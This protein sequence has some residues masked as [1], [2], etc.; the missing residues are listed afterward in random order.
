MA[1]FYTNSGSFNDLK[2]SGSTIMSASSGAVLQLKSSGSTIFSVSGSGG[3]IFN[4]S[5]IGSSTALFTVS[6][7][8][9]TILNIDNTKIASISGSLVIT[10]STY[11]KGLGTTSQNNVVT[12]DSSTGQ[13]YYTAS[14]AFGGGGS[15]TPGGSDTEIQFNKAGAFSGSSN[16]IFNYTNQ[17]LQQ[18]FSTTAS[19][20]WSHAEGYNTRALGSLS[21]A[22]GYNTQAWNEGAHSEG[23][24][25]LAQGNYSHAEG[26]STSTS[27]FYA[28]TEG[29]HTYAQ[30]D[31]SHAEGNYAQ[32]LGA[33]SHA[34]GTHTQAVGESS[35]AEGN[36]TQ[37]VGDY[38]HAEG[39]YTIASSSYSH[40]EGE[41]TLAIG[42]A[43]HAEGGGNTIGGK[44]YQSAINPFGAGF[45][46]LGTKY[47]DVSPDLP[48]TGNII[49]YSASIFTRLTYS[50]VTGYY[51]GDTV[52]FLDQSFDAGE[53]GSVIIVENP[54]PPLADIIFAGN[55]SHAEGASN[56]VLNGAAHAEGE[57]TIASGVGSHAEGTYTQAIG[58]YSHAEGVMT[59]AA[60]NYQHVQGRYNLISSIDSALIVGNGGDPSSRSNLLF[61]GGNEVQVTGSL[62]VTGSLKQ[63]GY[64]VK[65]YKVYT[66]LLSQNYDGSDEQFQNTGTLVIGRTYYILIDQVDSP[67]YDFTNVGAPSN[68]LGVYFV[69]TGTTPNSWGADEGGIDILRYNLGA[70]TVKVLENTIG[71]IWWTYNT[72]G[73]YEINSNGLFTTDKVQTSLTLWGDDA[74]T[75]RFGIVQL[76]STSIMYLNVLDG[77]Y[78]FTDFIGG[79]SNNTSIE[80]RVYN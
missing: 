11:I 29:D 25:T 40:A 14:S 61:A 20:Q 18:G 64:E 23:D 4:I 39:N 30:G 65:P 47:G 73:I 72:T 19:G 33:H 69:A 62:I 31:Y 3:E 63:N 12:I 51:G 38:S 53:S 27:G 41:N 9:T 35:H 75:P 57:Q 42:Y 76:N 68:T 46:Y 1:I 26:K 22:E 77:T 50:I 80:I 7:G 54:S 43:S 36:Y 45:L 74:S 34:E 8:S 49:F 32:S 56:R 37:A 2:V 66:A 58:N 59:V 16:F 67:G 78:S 60:G 6:S 24:G 15:G 71:N 13:L 44:A 70:P 21:H 48:S 79:A 17:S 52:F 5:D 28:H 55:Y 10:G